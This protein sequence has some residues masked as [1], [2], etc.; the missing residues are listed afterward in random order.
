M[1]ELPAGLD[2]GCVC[3][4]FLSIRCHCAWGGRRACGQ[5]G[6]TLVGFNHASLWLPMLPQFHWFSSCVSSTQ[7][8]PR[9]LVLSPGCSFQSDDDRGSCLWRWQDT[10]GG[11]T[12]AR[13]LG[14]KEAFLSDGLAPR[15]AG[16][17]VASGNRYSVI[18]G[19][20]LRG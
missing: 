10:L 1:Y 20:F 7:G 2:G 9:T 4:S 19:T 6:Q 8:R 3:C 12:S 16:Y 17:N 15:G 18:G 13:V 11:P 14:G 5:D